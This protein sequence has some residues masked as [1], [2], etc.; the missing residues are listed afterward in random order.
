[1]CVCVF[2]FCFLCMYI[3]YMKHYFTTIKRESFC[4]LIDDSNR[5]GIEELCPPASTHTAS[6]DEENEIEELEALEDASTDHSKHNSQ[7][8]LNNN[9]E[10]EENIR[11]SFQSLM[12]GENTTKETTEMPPLL[13]EMLK[14]RQKKAM[15]LMT[16]MLK[17]KPPVDCD[18]LRSLSVTKL[19]K[20]AVKYGVN[21]NG[22]VSKED[23]V[24]MLARS[25]NTSY[26][27]RRKINF[28]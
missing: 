16:P 2:T 13:M 10:E 27:F 14:L 26:M 25:L 11:R 7:C 6:L 1:M 24:Q 21:I 8:S 18:K 15:N 9:N 20:L 3:A 4:F 23:K 22:C 12:N 17:P 28:D 19:K 5:T